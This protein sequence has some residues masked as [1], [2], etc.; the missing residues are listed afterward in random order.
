MVD[1]SKGFEN[2]LLNDD[3]FEDG[4]RKDV[5][6][7]PVFDGGDDVPLPDFGVDDLVLADPV[8]S[9]VQLSDGTSYS[10][11]ENEF[12]HDFFDDSVDVSDGGVQLSDV[13]ESRLHVED[14]ESSDYDDEDDLLDFIHGEDDSVSDYDS[15]AV[16]AHRALSDYGDDDEDE[17]DSF[18]LDPVLNLAIDMGA[19]DVHIS[20]NDFVSFTILGDIVRIEDFGILSSQNTQNAY[21]EIVSHQSQSAF[22]QEFLL[23]SSYVIR[24]G[25]HVGR[26]LRLNVTKSYA[27]I[28]MVLRVIADTIPDP[29]DLNVP[30][31][32]MRWTKLPNGLVFLNGPTGVGKTTTLASLMRRM[33]MTRAQKLL[34]FENPIEFNYGTVGKALVTQHE[35]GMDTRTFAQGLKGAMREAPNIIM[36]G[37]VRDNIEINA[38]LTAAE[39]GH[40][41]VSTMHTISAP[42]A[43][44]RI[45]SQFRG[46]D[47]GRV[48]NTL[49]NVCRGIANQ[50]L[51]KSIDGKSRFAVFEVLNVDSKVRLLIA[52][53]DVQGIRDYQIENK[54]TMEHNLVRSVLSKKCTT[55]EA[56]YSASDPILFEEILKNR[57]V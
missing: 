45:M 51:L 34:T 28:S 2:P 36:V 30:T 3:D 33:Q 10:D 48:L 56:L 46:D 14:D 37:E 4:F 1:L 16:K 40:L 29:E 43:I 41:A 5:S 21:I 7:T 24:T 25:A 23:D 42:A 57:A 8:V 49:S 20:A 53:G 32:L 50:V 35:L 19:S 44:D 31:D 18:R 17:A 13:A 27:N 6:D 39:T 47:Q 9:D 52:Q 26:R 38:L 11:A 55:D 54:I 22:N 15:V 12:V